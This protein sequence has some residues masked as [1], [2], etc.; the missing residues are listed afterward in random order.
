LLQLV[1]DFLLVARRPSGLYGFMALWLYGF[2][3]LWLY[4]F[5]ALWLYG[6][7]ALGL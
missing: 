3:A 5:M 1:F 7:M 4:G 2:M 6:F